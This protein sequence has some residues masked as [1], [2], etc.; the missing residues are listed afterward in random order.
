MKLHPNIQQIVDAWPL[1]SFI[2]VGMFL[3]AEFWVEAKIQ[4][5]ILAGQDTPKVIAIE[6]D[7]AV[8][9]S[10]VER[11]EAALKEVGDDLDELNG[12]IKEVLRFLAEM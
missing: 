2:V 9:K 12:D 4:E 3:F 6:K 5:G 8:T 11:N 10:T 1:L 7:V